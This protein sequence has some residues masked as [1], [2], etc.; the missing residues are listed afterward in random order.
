MT[1]SELIEKIFSTVSGTVEEEE[2]IEKLAN[3]TG[4]TISVI[5]SAIILCRR[6]SKTAQRFR[7]CLNRRLRLGGPG[8]PG[9][10]GGRR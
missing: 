6:S 9:S 8:G 10:T 1:I 2:L 4:K 5:K 3:Q 7:S